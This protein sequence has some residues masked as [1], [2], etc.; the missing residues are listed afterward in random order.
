VPD[1]STQYAQLPDLPS[2]WLLNKR[3]NA[4]VAGIDPPPF[5]LRDMPLAPYD[6]KPP[7]LMVRVVR[8]ALSHA[9]RMVDWRLHPNHVAQINQRTNFY[10][11]ELLVSR[12]VAEPSIWPGKEEFE[13][14]M[15]IRAAHTLSEAG[16][17]KAYVAADI[18]VL[19]AEMQN[20][21]ASV[22]ALLQTDDHLHLEAFVDAC[23]A[24]VH[25]AG[26]PRSMDLDVLPE[27]EAMLARKN[28]TSLQ[29]FGLRKIIEYIRNSAPRDGSG[30]DSG[31]Q[32]PMSPGTDLQTEQPNFSDQEDQTGDHTE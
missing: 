25:A 1:G 7:S 14:V 24:Y 19:L 20:S 8:F 10:G 5:L 17:P 16:R 31:D 13:L 30:Q 12:T 11:L 27:W 18:P 9:Q 4:T 29:A 6:D 21:P 2:A 23:Y 3:L 15:A 26:Y 28:P 32:G 22:L